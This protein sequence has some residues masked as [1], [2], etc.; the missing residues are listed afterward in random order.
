MT[1]NVIYADITELAANPIRSGIQR[2]VR[3]F[4]RRWRGPRPLQPCIFRRDLADLVELPMETL[5]LL[6][7]ANP[8]AAAMSP[9][10]IAER[11]RA[12]TSAAPE[13]RVKVGGVDIV[14]PE[15]FYDPIR[16]EH[17]LWRQ[18]NPNTRLS[19]LIYD[20]IPWLHPDKIGVE[21]AGPLMHYLKL[22]TVDQNAAFIS[23][24][25]YDDWRLRILRQPSRPGTVLPLGADG[26]GLE[27]QRFDPAKR[28]IVCLGSIDG[29]KNQELIAR[30]F[31]EGWAK[32]LDLDLVM[33]GY[34]FNPSGA[35]AQEI[36]QIAA[37]SP[38]LKRHERATDEEVLEIMRGARATIYMS[39][40]EGYGLPPVESLHAGIPAI[41]AEGIPSIARMPSA[42]QI[43]LSEPTVEQIGAALRRISDDHE[44]RVLWNEAAS[45]NLPTWDQF[46][47][48]VSKWLH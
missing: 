16:V 11:V 33:I 40:L 3:E 12:M 18:T 20:F 5:D 31:A 42:G 30:A 24:Q 32:G 38:R 1:S 8:A 41:V 14:L 28:S 2:V 25:T 46:A 23:K 34:A 4:L 48:S 26:L 43:R 17:Y 10:E 19:L 39:N 9:A 36:A 6:T 15:L 45:L 47:D 21:R 7:D 35:P 13:R 44:A 22:T 37:H 27:R 29:R